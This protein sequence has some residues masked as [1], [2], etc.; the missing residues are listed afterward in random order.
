[1]QYIKLFPSRAHNF[2]FSQASMT[3]STLSL[4]L[5]S[6]EDS[7]LQSRIS[8]VKRGPIH[9]EPKTKG[10]L[11]RSNRTRDTPPRGRGEAQETTS[12]TALELLKVHSRV[13]GG[14]TIQF[15]FMD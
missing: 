5:A 2:V 4:Y 7:V 15:L 3:G 12:P 1:M 13:G 8:P 10:N 14:I 9:D 11:Q 6:Q